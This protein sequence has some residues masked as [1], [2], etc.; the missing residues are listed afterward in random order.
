MEINSTKTDLNS[1]RKQIYL[2]NK[3]RMLSKRNTILILIY[4]LQI[5][6]KTMT[7][8]SIFLIKT[9]FSQLDFNKTKNSTN[10]KSLTNKNYNIFNKEKISFHQIKGIPQ[11]Q[12]R[13]NQVYSQLDK[14]K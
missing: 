14:K 7:K 9:N 4:C 12:L 13:K 3:A 1:L 2:E 8:M 6:I 10:N 11:S 5:L